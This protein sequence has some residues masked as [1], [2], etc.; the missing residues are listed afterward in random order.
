MLKALYPSIIGS[1]ILFVAVLATAPVDGE[2]A[3]NSA[4]T[5]LNAQVGY[6]GSVSCRECHEKFYKLWA[7]SN[8]GLAMQPYTEEFAKKNLA[9]QERK[10]Q[11]GEFTYQAKIGLDQGYVLEKGTEG[12]KKYPITEVLGGKNVYYFLTPME[13]GRLQT[14]PVAFDVHQ[15]EWFDTAASGLRHVADEPFHWRES[16][17][18]FNTACFSCHVSQ[19]R[20]NYDLK[21]DTYQTTW[22]EPGINCETCHGPAAE[23]IRVCRE[24]PEGTIPKDLKITRGGRDFTHEQNNAN[25]STCHAKMVPITDSFIP[26]DKFFDHCDLI[27]L[28]AS[29]Y[30]PDGRDLGENYTYTTWLLSPCVKSGELDCLHCHT[31]SG[32]FRQIKTPNRACLPCH[33]ERVANAPKHTRHAEGSDGNLCISCHMPMSEF[34]RMRRS[35]HSMLPPTPAATLAF[36]SPNACNLCHTDKDAVWADRQVRKWRERDYQAPLLY[37][38]KLVDAARKNDWTN[39]AEML[40]YIT[41]PERDE[42][43]ATSLIRLLD[44]CPDNQKW[45]AIQ[46]AIKDKSPLVRGAATSALATHLTP[47]TCEALLTCLEDNYR[48]VRI[49]AASSLA[50]YPRELLST[51]DQQRLEKATQ[52]LLNSFLSRP[53]NWTSHYNLG[54]YYSERK[55]FSKAI[56]AFDTASRLQPGSVPPLINI[57]IIHARLGRNDLAESALRRALK[58]APDNAEANFNLGLLLA[59]QGKL[60]EAEA[61]L[62]TAL[63]YDPQFPE[64]AYNLGVLLSRDRLPEALHWF[65]KAHELRP[66]VPKYSFSLAFY[67][68]QQGNEKEAIEVLNQQVQQKATSADIYFLL[69]ELYEKTDRPEAA[70]EVYQKALADKGLPNGIRHHFETRILALTN[71]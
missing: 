54:N 30:Y 7:S 26:G 69:G 21:T 19:F 35:D 63:K 15:K 25:C 67:L 48:L 4:V 70:M 12:E 52:E 53:D 45:P 22:K 20:L 65:R 47:D 9:P 14:L 8:H 43:Y 59:E 51:A 50:S 1:F 32:R 39:L 31:S 62:R 40:K 2:S 16:V 38:A 56:E 66:R 44:F 58:I 28:E 10:T 46:Q 57:S 64:A 3:S 33:E 6:T 37:R 18:T 41:N 68:R 61:A 36:K 13:R 11:I 34:A 24:A 60:P 55:E 27:T 17:Y 5:P 42:I 23:H 29:D 49:R 71:K